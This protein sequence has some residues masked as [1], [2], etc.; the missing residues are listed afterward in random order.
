MGNNIKK[1]TEAYQ[2]ILSV[3]N[4]YK[5][6]VR[7][8]YNDLDVEAKKHLFEIELQEK[9]G[10]NIGKGRVDSLDYIRINDYCSI[11]WWGEKYRR[12]IS[13]LD[14]GKQPTD[15]LLV[16]FGFSTGAYIFGDDYPKEFFQEFWNE[17]KSYNPTYIDTTNKNMYFSIDTAK[18]VFNK[19]PDI[20]K[21]YYKKNEE[22]A[23]QREIKRLKE[24]LETLSN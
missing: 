17:L 24:K 9:Y 3:L 20:L 19:F 14:E 5:D 16:V 18:D 1:V 7:Y 23:K 21:K 2:E 6:I 13:W 22:D 11:S 10:L 4:K 12:T 15:E 8:N